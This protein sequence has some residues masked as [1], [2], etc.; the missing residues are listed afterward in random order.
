[1]WCAE[2]RQPGCCDLRNFAQIH[3]QN[4]VPYAGNVAH[5][6]LPAFAAKANNHEPIHRSE[7][8]DPFCPPAALL[9]K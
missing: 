3:A 1:M 7:Q 4:L 6:T 2:T 8:N 9:G 5:P